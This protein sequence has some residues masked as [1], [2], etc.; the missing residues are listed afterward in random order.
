MIQCGFFRNMAK[1]S[2][3]FRV[4]VVEDELLIRWSIVETLTSAGYEVIEA[5]SAAAAVRALSSPSEPLDAVLLDY[6]LPDSNDLTLLSN[7]RRLS[8]GSAV[9][10]MTAFGTP[11]VTKGA[12]AL[13]VY[14]VLSKPFDLHDLAPLLLEARTQTLHRS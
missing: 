3:S 7:I 9:V 4:L 2:P 1:N 5:D 11:E 6:R 13:G 10:M 14:K 12:L 8:P